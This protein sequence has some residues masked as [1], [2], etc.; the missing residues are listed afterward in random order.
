MTEIVINRPGEVFLREWPGVASRCCAAPHTRP[1]SLARQCDRDLHRAVIDAQKPILSAMLP[2][3]E[4]VQIVV[5]PA[6]ETDTVSMSIRRPSAS[7]RTLPEYED[8]GA[9]DRYVWARSPHS[10]S[11]R[12]I[13]IP[14]TSASRAPGPQ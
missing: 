2:D 7:I 10:Q 8:S 9:F 3:G 11:G 4:R 13:W 12:R 5:P 1:M 14:W 6:G